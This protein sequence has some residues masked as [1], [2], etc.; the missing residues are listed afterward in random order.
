MRY[1]TYKAVIKNLNDHFD[2]QFKRLHLNLIK[3]SDQHMSNQ[4]SN[5]ATGALR[6]SGATTHH[7]CIK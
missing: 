2:F 1:R 5:K 7:A 3:K 6:M 4:V